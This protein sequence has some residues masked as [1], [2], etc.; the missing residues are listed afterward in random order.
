MA[1]NNSTEGLWFSRNSSASIGVREFTVS[2]SHTSSESGL[3]LL[4]LTHSSYNSSFLSLSFWCRYHSSRTDGT[5]NYVSAGWFKGHITYVS[6][7][8]GYWE[9]RMA[10]QYGSSNQNY[11]FYPYVDRSGTGPGNILNFKTHLYGSPGFS[12]IVTYNVIIMYERWDLVT[13]SYP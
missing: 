7:T 2:K 12:N 10:N 6:G 5:P 1:L 3:T 13:I 4:S 11:T 9:T 8:P